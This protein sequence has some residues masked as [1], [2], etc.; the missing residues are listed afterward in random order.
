MQGLVVNGAKVY[1][2]ALPTE[3]IEDR[4]TEL[5]DLGRT[6]GGSA[7]GWVSNGNIPQLAASHLQLTE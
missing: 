6:T 3:S 7:I 2:V 1:L 4:V 5:C